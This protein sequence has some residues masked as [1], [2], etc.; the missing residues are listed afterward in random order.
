MLSCEGW[1]PK[2]RRGC[3][4]RHCAQFQSPRLVAGLAGLDRQANRHVLK[5]LANI[6]AALAIVWAVS[7]PAF[8]F[9]RAARQEQSRKLSALASS[10]LGASA[11][12]MTNDI[13]R[14]PRASVEWIGDLA[15]EERERENILC[16]ILLA[17][18]FVTV[19]L[20]VMVLT[21]KPENKAA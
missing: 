3:E 18:S 13:I 2:N 5:R 12:D 4:R 9:F 1:P 20:A 15:Q 6:F 21:R 19:L 11:Q 16:I 14:V 10:R 7:A 8:V 17:S